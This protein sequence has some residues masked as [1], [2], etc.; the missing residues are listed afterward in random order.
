MRLK[1]AALLTCAWLAGSA[2]AFGQ[3]V[4]RGTEVT[5]NPIA[6]GSSGTLLY[7]GGQYMRVVHPALQPGETVR[8]MGP[9]QLHMP[10]RH[11]A[12][13]HKA[14]PKTVARAETSPK[15]EPKPA[16]PAR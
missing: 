9:I 8:D 7:P 14:S 1:S 6:G 12:S 10:G 4:D 11:A 5:V 13:P 3:T 16:A 15:S 2:M